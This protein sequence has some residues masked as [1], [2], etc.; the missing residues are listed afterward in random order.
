MSEREKETYELAPAEELSEAATKAQRT[1]LKP[2]VVDRD[3]PCQKCGYNLRGVPAP[4]VCPE[5]GRPI[6]RVAPAGEYKP[7]PPDDMLVRAPIPF[8]RLLR[9]GLAGMLFSVAAAVAL[10]IGTG[11]GADLESWLLLATAG[12][13]VSVA[14][15]CRRRP[16]QSGRE[17]PRND[18][19]WLRAAGVG[20]QAC[21]FAGVVVDMSGASG[22]ANILSIIAFVGL[23]PTAWWIGEIADWAKDPDTRRLIRF[24]VGWFVVFGVLSGMGVTVR[25]P[26]GLPSLSLLLFGI[27]LVVV[28]VFLSMLASLWALARVVGEAGWAVRTA[29]LNIARRK[30]LRDT[31]N[32]ERK[33]AQQQ[34][35]VEEP[36]GG[37]VP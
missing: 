6:G 11:A 2:A 31:T 13:L 9:L 22:V 25:L 33:E 37:P 30:E 24:S 10:A 27:D 18:V 12:W 32:A 35:I 15:V 28:S 1:A 17:R 16:D 34:R 4:G 3:L 26:L 36:F 23:V 19:V 20:T 29:K 8:I 7:L 21:W 14:L 5:C